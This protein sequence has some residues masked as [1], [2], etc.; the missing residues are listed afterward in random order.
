MKRI[1]EIFY[2]KRI[3][4]TTTPLNQRITALEAE[5]LTANTQL[6]ELRLENKELLDR[7]A[8]LTQQLPSTNHENG[9]TKSRYVTINLPGEL[10]DMFDVQLRGT[11]NGCAFDYELECSGS[12]NL[13]LIRSKQTS[14]YKID[15]EV[16]GEGPVFIRIK[17]QIILNDKT[18]I[19]FNGFATIEIK[20]DV[21]DFFVVDYDCHPIKMMYDMAKMN[22]NRIDVDS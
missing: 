7:V 6:A 18:S 11:Y 21:E 20:P 13:L 16:V 8:K 10:A 9:L 5:L 14:V 2:R 19:S 15:L 3:A 1:F 22:T 17:Q 4:L 12:N